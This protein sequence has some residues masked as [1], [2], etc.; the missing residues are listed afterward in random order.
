MKKKK[1]FTV[2][3]T[4]TL[5]AFDEDKV[6]VDSALKSWCHK[7]S[8]LFYCVESQSVDPMYRRPNKAFM[9][10][11]HSQCLEMV[12]FWNWLRL[13]TSYLDV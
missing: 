12:I 8:L 13:N 10:T 6:Y 5:G 2:K 11:N 3:S 7:E 1:S 4:S 9:K